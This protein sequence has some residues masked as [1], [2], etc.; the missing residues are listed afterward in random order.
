MLISS[1]DLL[2]G[3]QTVT[4]LSAPFPSPKTDLAKI[5]GGGEEGMLLVLLLLL[6]GFC[7]VQT[8]AKDGFLSRAKQPLTVGLCPFWSALHNLSLEG[9]SWPHQGPLWTALRTTCLRN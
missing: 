2:P 4:S 6:G 7:T 9:G 8:G 3:L 1:L 5:R